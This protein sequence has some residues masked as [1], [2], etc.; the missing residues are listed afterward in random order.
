MEQEVMKNEYIQ[1]EVQG[2]VGVITLNRPDKANA[3][4]YPLLHE[5]N[6]AWMAAAADDAVRVILLRANGKHFSAGHDLSG[7]PPDPTTVSPLN[8][9]GSWSLSRIYTNELRVYFGYSLSWR[10]VPKP[11]I[12]AVQGKC[13]AGGL[14]LCWPCDIIIAAD[15]AEFSDP[16]IRMGIGGV[17]YHGHTLEFGARKAKELLFTGHAIDA[18]T[19]ER[20]GMVNRVVPLED[21]QPEAMALA[22]EIAQHDPFALLQAKRAVNQTL[23]VMGYTSAL[24]AVFDIHEVGHGAAI[25]K[26]GYPVLMR[27]D[28]MKAAIKDE[29]QPARK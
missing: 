26:S 12:A 21:L 13:I 3:Q 20:L 8:P 10:N 25:A 22:V 14:M 29:E 11:S 15:N 17:E 6:E 19:A 18:K 5:L 24:Q 2:A 23:D 28:A 16:V 27:L 7:G 4:H 9:D 1:Y